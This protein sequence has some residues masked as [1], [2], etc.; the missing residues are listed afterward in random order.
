MSRFEVVLMLFLISIPLQAKDEDSTYRHPKYA[1][2]ETSYVFGG[3]VY[4]L[5]LMYDPGFAIQ[6]SYGLMLNGQVGLGLGT[7]YMQLMDERF[8][9]VYAEVVGYLKDKPGTPVIRMQLGYS[10][11]WYKGDMSMEGYEFHGG[12][13]FDA[14]LGRKITIN[15][16]YAVI[17]QCS[18]RHQFAKMEYEVYGGREYKSAMNYDM[19][20]FTLGFVIR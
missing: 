4:N 12:M 13:C 6:A 19:L 17:F 11:G 18:Y 3:Q 20:L 8:L 5:K 14:G 16:K 2:V 15:D 9:P 10:A 7:G 1:R